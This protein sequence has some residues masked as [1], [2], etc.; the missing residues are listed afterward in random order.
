MTELLAGIVL[1]LA[2]VVVCLLD[3]KLHMKRWKKE[4]SLKNLSESTT[5]KLYK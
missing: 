5:K 2:F 3:L 1:F 4:Q